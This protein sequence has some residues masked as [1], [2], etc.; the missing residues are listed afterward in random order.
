MKKF[1]LLLSLLVLCS[2]LYAQDKGTWKTWYENFLKSLKYK[3]E[4]KISP[5]SKITAVA[6]VRGS[7]QEDKSKEIYWKG[8]NSKKAQ[9]K[10][11]SDRKTLKEAIENIVNGD[12]EKGRAQLKGFIDKNPDSYFIT[13]AKEALE[14]LPAQEVKPEESAPEVKQEKTEVKQEA[15]TEAKTESK[16]SAASSK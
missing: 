1:T 5:R 16:D 12:M 10:I 15:Q 11:E 14:K 7:K 6:A 9:E 3:V 4:K 13:E 2:S 8:S